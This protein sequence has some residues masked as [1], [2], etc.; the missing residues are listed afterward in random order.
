F[1]TRLSQSPSSLDVLV[2][3]RQSARLA[4]FRDFQVCCEK[5]T[6]ALMWLKE[7][8]H[9]YAEITIDEE[10]LQSLPTNG[11]VD[12][13]LTNNEIAAEESDNEV[14]D[15]IIMRT[16]V[17]SLSPVHRE[18]ITINETLNHMQ[19]TKREQFSETTYILPK[20]SD[21]DVV[22]I[23]KLRAL[24][25]PVAK[26]IATH[27]GDNDAKRADSDT[28]HGLESKLLL[29]RGA[30]VM[31]TANIWTESG[32]VNGSLGTVQDILFEDHGPPCLPVAVFVTFD[33]YK[34]PTITN[35][36]GTKVVPITLIKRTWEGKTGNACSHTQIPLRLAWSITVH[37][38]QGLT[39]PKAYISLGEREFSA[40]LSLVVK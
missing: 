5:V 40:G 20:W 17:P 3:H 21:V 13:Q 4:S 26:I 28:A 36:E 14:E 7:N 25:V 32:L 8:N 11:Y 2:V 18:D 15:D 6:C 35:V 31:P 24:N 33:R 1:T 23:D 37:K 29:A 22:N 30:R 10:V 27:T 34:R 19:S 39:L 16:F 9:Y 38:S 12:D